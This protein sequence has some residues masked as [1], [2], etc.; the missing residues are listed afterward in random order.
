METVV[1]TSLW[2]LLFLSMTVVDIRGDDERNGTTAQ[3]NATSLNLPQENNNNVQGSH[4]K[5]SNYTEVVLNNDKRYGG[6]YRRGGGGGG[7]GGGGWGWG[8]GGGGWY[9]WG[10]GKG[11]GGG[12]GGGGRGRRGMNNMHMHRKREVEK[13]EYKIGEYA[14]CMGEGR[15][16]WMRLDCPLH[17]GGPCFYDCQHMCKAHCRRS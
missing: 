2:F 16:K 7:G 15:C 6:Y 5:I 14:Q 11:K 8:G 13:L 17:C 9:K 4:N 10:C 1:M 12:G 3:V